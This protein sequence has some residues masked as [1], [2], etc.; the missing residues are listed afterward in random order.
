MRVHSSPESLFFRLMFSSMA[1]GSILQAGQSIVK[2]RA[3]RTPS[4][5][6][7]FRA[8]EEYRLETHRPAYGRYHTPKKHRL[9]ATCEAQLLLSSSWPRN[10]MLATHKSL[11]KTSLFLA[12]ALLIAVPA[13]A[14]SQLIVSSATVTLNSN[15][16]HTIQVTASGTT[17]VTYTVSGLPFWL[18][19]F[20]T[21]NFTTPD[22]LAFQLANSSCGTCTATI[23]LASAGGTPVM[24]TVTYA[25]GTSG[26]GGTITAS[27]TSFQFAYPS[28]TLS[29]MV[30]IG[31]NNPSV[32]NF[33]VT[34]AS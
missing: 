33:N 13:R 4:A 14:Q 1:R 29:A 18:S 9:S 11:M 24:V 26:G 10:V 23:T 22:T 28:G 8:V 17:A 34:I 31:S 6:P 20:S 7:P 21:N 3:C 30:T 12:G 19:A 32:T 2:L 5:R 25:P 15:Q 16:A 27:Q